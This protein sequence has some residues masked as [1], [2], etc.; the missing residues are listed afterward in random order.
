MSIDSNKE[1]VRKFTRAI[2]SPDWETEIAKFKMITFTPEQMRQWVL[3]HR[4]FR[5]TF[6]DYHSEILE[7]IAEG[8]K[9]VLI[10][11]ITGTHRSEFPYY[12]LKGIR[13]T[14]LKLEWQEMQVFVIKDDAFDVP[15]FMVDG[16]SRLKQLGVLP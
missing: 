6:P 2:N 10:T 12:E 14:D 15:Y 11:K 13:A 9:V 1:M 3:E 7:L 4:A 5:K 8:D 16:V